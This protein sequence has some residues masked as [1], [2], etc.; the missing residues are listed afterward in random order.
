[1]IEDPRIAAAWV[2]G[3]LARGDEDELS[4][5]DVMVVVHESDLHS[6]LAERY[7]FVSGLGDPVM[8][9][10]APQNR[11][12]GGAYNMVWYAGA[13]GPH[14]VDWSWSSSATTQI[15]T[16]VRLL[17]NRAGLQESGEPMEFAYQ[18]VPERDRREEMRQ[19]LH[20]FWSMLLVGAKHAARNPYEDRMG[21]LQWTVPQLREAQLF[22]GVEPGLPFEDMPSHPAPA[23]KISA[24]RSLAAEAS[25][26]AGT[27]ADQ[28]V[29]APIGIEP[30][31]Q[32]YLDL[33]E[34]VMHATKRIYTG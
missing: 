9:L 28:G 25:A 3:S 6:F 18:P 27:L 7:D 17:H 14:A 8:V 12:P 32:C 31:A 23:D 22:A 13:H 34:A 2:F 30:Y 10:E 19:A 4:D 20:G 24:L 1:M 21:L 15:P 26:L 33:I 5:Y 16:G 11:P 29:V